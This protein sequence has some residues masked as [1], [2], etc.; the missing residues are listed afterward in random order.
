[1]DR[2]RK[3]AANPLDR[4]RAKPQKTGVQ[5][6]HNAIETSDIYRGAYLLCC[7]GRVMATRIERGQVNFLIEGEGVVEHDTRYRLGIA[8]V[9]PVQLRETLNLLRD[10]VFKKLRPEMEKKHD[11]HSYR[12]DRTAQ[13]NG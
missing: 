12:R 3:I 11:P 10:L 9:N 5:P 6:M 1:M 4:V 13:A 8:L 2:P 7:G